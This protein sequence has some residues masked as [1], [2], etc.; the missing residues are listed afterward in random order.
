MSDEELEQL[1]ATAFELSDE[2]HQA[3]EAEISPPPGFDVYELKET[4][5]L[6]K[7]RDL[8]DALLAKGSPESAGIQAYLVDDNTVRMDWFLSNLLGGIKLQVQLEDVEAANEILNQ[9][10]PETL[11]IESGENYT[12]PKCPAC[13]SL[14]VSYRELNKLA[15][16]GSAY[17]GVPI[18]VH[19]KAW[20]CHA[21]RHEWEERAAVPESELGAQ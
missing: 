13:Q 7:F 17:F 2:G 21:C 8:P 3:L 12:Q 9:P 19:K 5:T 18:P 15:S 20:A 1:A 16:F 11:E 4:V 14:D 10:I 6:R